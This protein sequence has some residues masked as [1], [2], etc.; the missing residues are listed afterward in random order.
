MS[1]DVESVLTVI[2]QAQVYKL[3]PRTTAKGYRAADWDPQ[4][5]WQGRVKIFTIGESCFINLEDGTTGQL[6]AQCPYV[7]GTNSVEPVTDSS[8]YFVVKVVDQTTKQHAFIGLGFQ[9]RSDSFDFNVV[10][11]DFERRKRQE[12]EAL[13]PK[14]VDSGPKVDFSLKE[15]ETISINI[16][17]K[18]AGSVGSLVKP[19]QP[20]TGCLPFLPPPPT[21]RRTGGAAT[22]LLD[23]GAAAPQVAP[24]QPTQASAPAG[25]TTF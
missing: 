22:S 11:Q 4:H 5:L 15:G 18:K 24:S 16:G 1:A 7:P 12:A 9:E 3:P 25:W 17:G 10:L 6:F 8:R 14:P 13:K 21:V 2:R 23:T 20:A 19:E